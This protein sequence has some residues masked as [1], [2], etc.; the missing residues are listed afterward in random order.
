MWQGGGVRRRRCSRP[1]CLQPPRHAGRLESQQ[2]A[3][4]LVCRW[5]KAALV[6]VCGAIASAASGGAGCGVFASFALIRN[7]TVLSHQHPGC[8]PQPRTKRDF[9]E[10]PGIPAAGKAAT[11]WRADRLHLHCALVG[12]RGLAPIGCSV[13]P[14]VQSASAMHTATDTQGGSRASLATLIIAWR[15]P[16]WLRQA[17][18]A[19][20]DSSGAGGLPGTGSRA[21]PH[22]RSAWATHSWSVQRMSLILPLSSPQL[23]LAHGQ[24]C[25]AD[26]HAP[27][28]PSCG[29]GLN[30]GVDQREGLPE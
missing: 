21:V 20:A 29:T 12:R 1:Q 28:A 5:A 26:A 25:A 18:T 6:S 23:L 11:M 8:S 16:A 24:H 22:M 19:V 3:L 17:P 14:S 9:T 7:R 15:L 13:N 4:L 27:V 2:W 30:Q 10:A